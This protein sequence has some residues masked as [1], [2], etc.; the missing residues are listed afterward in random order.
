MSLNPRVKHAVAIGLVGAVFVRLAIALY[1]RLVGDDDERPTIR[2]RNG[3]S[4]RVS[5]DEGTFVKEDKEW[6]QKHSG[7]LGPRRLE[8]EII[9]EHTCTKG[10]KLRG[11]D[12]RVLYG[13]NGETREMTVSVENLGHWGDPH[14]YANPDH[15]SCSVL[16]GDVVVIDKDTQMKLLSVEVGY[17]TC[18]FVDPDDPGNGLDIHPKR[19]L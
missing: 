8:V 17:N 14:V 16:E 1:R 13:V 6:R 2:V 7:S 12:V 19:K 3:A 18:T 10:T 15:R 11:K 5:T 9:G 4:I